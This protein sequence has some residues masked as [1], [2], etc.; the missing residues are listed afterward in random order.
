MKHCKT[1]EHG[2]WAVLNLINEKGFSVSNFESEKYIYDIPAVINMA[3]MRI[4]ERIKNII[5]LMY[6]IQKT[7]Q[8]FI[9]EDNFKAQKLVFLIQKRF[10]SKKM[11]GFS[12]PFFRWIKGPFS[13]SLNSDLVLLKKIGFVRWADDKIELTEDGKD[14]LEN[15]SELL[16]ENKKF[17][18]II[19]RVVREFGH[20][21]PEEMEEKVYQMKI[22]VPKDK[23]A[24][25]IEQITH[26]KVMDGVSGEKSETEFSIREDVFDTLEVLLDNEATDLL[27]Q[28]QEDA[29]KGN[30]VE[31]SSI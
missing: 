14:V 11:N 28:A 16:R 3:Q 7:T 26:K 2:I 17:L 13:A 31:F 19:D 30:T 4:F 15:C 22:F 5:L 23:K 21:S 24:M 18:E 20:F 12:Y 25:R 1:H 10:V 27:R 8:E 29:I 6:M 9:L